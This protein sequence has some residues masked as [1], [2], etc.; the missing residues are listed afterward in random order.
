M[1]D[2]EEIAETIKDTLRAIPELK[3]VSDYAGRIEDV[4]REVAKTPGAFV[5]YNGARLIEEQSQGVH[6]LVDVVFSVL[7]VSREG[8]IHGR[9]Y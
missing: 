6:N 9:N 3:T 1:L 2:I 8:G 7:I 4:I 5:V